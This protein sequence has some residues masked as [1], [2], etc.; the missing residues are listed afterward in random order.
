MA[1]TAE[2]RSEIDEKTLFAMG[3]IY[4]PAHH[5]DA[6]RGDRGVCAQCQEVITYSLERTAA[7]PHDHQGNC[8]DCE[9]HC[10]KPDMRAGI[11]E[12]MRYAGPRMTFR[13]PVLTAYYLKKKLRKA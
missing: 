11:Q 7:C 1:Q 13:H 10:Y 2:K 8:K 4:C 6:M 12:I 9:I 3:A 5:A